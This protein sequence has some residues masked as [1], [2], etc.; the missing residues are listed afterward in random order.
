[1]TSSQHANIIL[2]NSQKN[3]SIEATAIGIYENTTDIKE[4]QI[5]HQHA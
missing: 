4:V 5:Y 3:Q 1:M 2:Q